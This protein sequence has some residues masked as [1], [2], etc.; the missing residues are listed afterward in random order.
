MTELLRPALYNAYHQIDFNGIYFRE[1]L[2]TSDIVG[3]ICET[4][5]C[6]GEN[7]KLPQLKR[8]DLL[9]IRSCGAYAE[10]MQLSYNGRKKTEALLC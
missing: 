1:K 10:S 5:D 4:S 3:P 9:T 2:N 8:G 6:L 7:I